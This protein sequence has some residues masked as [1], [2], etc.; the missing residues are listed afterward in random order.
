[1]DYLFVW[2]HVGS[3]MC[4]VQPRSTSSVARA[5]KFFRPTKLSIWDMSLECPFWGESVKTKAICTT[6]ILYES[7]IPLIYF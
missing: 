6:D 7:T 2:G 5:L 4:H 1:M 3:L